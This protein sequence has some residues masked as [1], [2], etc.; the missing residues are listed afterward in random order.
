[1]STPRALVIGAAAGWRAVV[2][3]LN[4][5][6]L[7]HRNPVVTAIFYGLV[8]SAIV[9]LVADLIWH[10][11]KDWMDRTIGRSQQ[12]AVLSAE[13][14]ARH[15]RLRTLLPIFRNVLGVS[16]LVMA[17]LAELGVEIGPLIAGAGIFG[18][19]L[20]FGSQRLV[21]YIISCLFYM[22][23]DTFRVRGYIQSKDY[24]GTV[25]GF[26]LRSVRLRHHRGPVFTIPFGELGAVQNMS[27]DWSVIKFIV[28]VGY[29]T[30]VGKVKAITK[31]IWKELANDPEFHP[32]IIETLKMKGLEKF[33]EY[34]ID[35]S[36]G[37]MLRPS[38]IL[39]MIRRRANL[40]LR[41][42]FKENGIS[43]AT[44]SV[45]VEGDDRSNAA[46]VVTA[47]RRGKSRQRSP[48]RSTNR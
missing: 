27:R 40:M 17:V 33:G 6:S 3:Q 7:G 47:S 8:K 10:L 42:A 24:K 30:D 38:P 35:L 1:M 25:E 29:E 9:L 41:E 43:F 39:S 2:W 44:P 15:G 4:W 16:V 23:D 26:S 14:A 21:K 20:G 13:E 46:A 12:D 32:L 18:I 36:F 45:Q 11:A 37:M 34:G 22:L 31:T 19:A 28:S 48:K 5:D